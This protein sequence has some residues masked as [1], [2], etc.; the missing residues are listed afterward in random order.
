MPSM[1]RRDA[2]MAGDSNNPFY[3]NTSHWR[4]VDGILEG[5]EQR[6]GVMV[7]TGPPGS[8]KTMLMRAISE[9]LQETT[10]P[11]FLQ[12]ASL[13]FREFVNFLHS[14]LKIED[15][16]ADAPNKAVALRE[17]LYVQAKRDET[18][19]V[20]I[21]E[22][23][24]LEPDVLKMLPK[25]ARFDA[26]ED[27][28]AVGLQF[29]LIGSPDL[30][31]I[32]DDPDF[33]EV[34]AKVK[35]HYELRFFTREELD[36]FLKKRLAPIARTTDEPI[37]PDAIDTIGKY[38]GGSPRLVGMICSHA[39]LFAAENPGKSIDSKMVEEAAE[40]LMMEPAE[41]P[42][43][44]DENMPDHALGPYS[45]GDLNGG[46]AA[47]P[48]SIFSRTE[49]VYEDAPVAKRAADEIPAA[50]AANDDGSARRVAAD[51]MPP[52]RSGEEGKD[53]LTVTN[54]NAAADSDADD[55]PPTRFAVS[56]SGKDEDDFDDV[57][58]FDDGY[59]L[60]DDFD[61]DDDFGDASISSS[62]D[63]LGSGKK[64]KARKGASFL[65]RLGI[66]G[67]SKAAKKDKIVGAAR[68]RD[69]V[70]KPTKAAA[71]PRTRVARE[72]GQR[73]RIPAIAAAGLLVVGG[74][75]WA[76]SKFLSGK[77]G[78]AQIAPAQTAQSFD[79]APVPGGDTDPIDFAMAPQVTPGGGS[80]DFGSIA[81]P[82]PA[83][84]ATNQPLVQEPAQLPA[85]LTPPDTQTAAATT[86]TTTTTTKSSGGWGAA[87]VI[88]SEPTQA[89][90]LVAAIAEPASGLAA[91]ALEQVERVLN[92]GEAKASD[93]FS[94]VLRAASDQVR[95]LRDSLI[96]PDL[97]PEEARARADEL[98][99]E[100]DAHFEA[101]RL[102]SPGDG[103]AYDSYRQALNLDAENTRA[104]AG[105]DKLRAFY[106]KKAE[107]AR[108]ARMW[109]EANSFFETAIAISNLRALPR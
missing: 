67:K 71:K 86:T 9:Q 100:G 15:E 29:V 107:G 77:P 81:I 50:N 106:A 108:E 61:D 64:D 40:A 62:T 24:N 31:E 54:L 57:S 74:G 83:I 65:Q 102:V 76:A 26:L 45:E 68:K 8:G 59:D 80:G 99:R 37:T 96:T 43:A 21:D 49:T 84:P 63:A 42:F 52:K 75:G 5:V 87:V 19:V 34:R 101:K 16:I 10:P 89:S 88:K 6:G 58:D 12:Y 28:R 41:N 2:D 55:V 3:F 44:D 97:S 13:N 85:E 60:D 82:A 1:P 7:L 36:Q 78:T 18:A 48:A 66:G 14:Q 69:A 4:A 72:K 98:S 92:T 104:K 23:H 47:Q 93:G 33:T 35:R 51:V 32:L 103:N 22:A 20:F 17:F 73:S 91:G 90:E 95:G 30:L 38:T 94:G 46:L 105:I 56:P 79:P 11:L 27:G 39:M 25:L 53:S 70:P 109:E